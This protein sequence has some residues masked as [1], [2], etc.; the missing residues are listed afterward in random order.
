MSS[1]LDKFVG[2][3]DSV[4]RREITPFSK[5]LKISFDRLVQDNL[6]YINGKKLDVKSADY[7][8]R[9]IVNGIFIQ[10]GWTNVKDFL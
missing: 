4:P 10:T 3:E 6:A 2:F 7:N 1:I 9:D 5:N 8:T